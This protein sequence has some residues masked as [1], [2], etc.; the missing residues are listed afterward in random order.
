MNLEEAINKVA[1]TKEGQVFLNYLMSEVCGYDK[2]S[3]VVDRNESI[4]PNGVL[5]N[6]F[7]RS[8]W[9]ELRQIIDRDKLIEIEYPIDEPETPKETTE[10]EGESL[11]GRRRKQRFKR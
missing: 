9:V 11:N 2:S 10:D 1:S 8:V 3:L 6:E 4:E 7:R 5:H